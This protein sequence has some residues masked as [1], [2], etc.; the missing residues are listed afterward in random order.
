MIVFDPFLSKN[1][2][3]LT[4]QLGKLSSNMSKNITVEE[5]VVRLGTKASSR[6]KK[7]T[8][9]EPESNKHGLERIL[10]FER[11]RTNGTSHYNVSVT[12]D[13]QIMIFRREEFMNF[14]SKHRPIFI[15][16][17]EQMV[18][19]RKNQYFIQSLK[20]LRKLCGMLKDSNGEKISSTQQPELIKDSNFSKLYFGTGQVS[21]QDELG[22]TLAVTQKPELKIIKYKSSRSIPRQSLADYKLKKIHSQRSIF[23]T[24]LSFDRVE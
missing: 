11:D 1:Q 3:V 24:K 22:P 8:F 9:Q 10:G 15:D 5:H 23:N 16:K 19:W 20:I 17:L 12:T 6:G 2:I 13:S 18:N 14:L 21:L 4:Q 7:V